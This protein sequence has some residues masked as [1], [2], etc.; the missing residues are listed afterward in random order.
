MFNVADDVVMP[1][2]MTLR[3]LSSPTASTA[4]IRYGGALNT[5]TTDWTIESECP[6]LRIGYKKEGE[7]RILRTNGT[8]L[9]M[10]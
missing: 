7:I 8:I 1:G 3:A 10:R 9:F 6:Y 2:S 5:K 4:L